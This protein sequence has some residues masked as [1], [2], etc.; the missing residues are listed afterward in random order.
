M[1]VFQLSL[2]CYHA[3]CLVTYFKYFLIYLLVMLEI[4]I[5]YKQNVPPVGSCPM[6]PSSVLLNLRYFNSLQMT[7]NTNWP[8]SAGIQ[9]KS[10]FCLH[11]TSDHTCWYT[12]YMTVI[13][14]LTQLNIRLTK[15]T[16]MDG[17]QMACT[18][19]PVCVL[20]FWGCCIVDCSA[21]SEWTYA[22]DAE[23]GKNSSQKSLYAVLSAGSFVIICFGIQTTWLAHM[24]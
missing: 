24:I 7:G 16:E 8:V 4:M 19:R 12:Q 18:W 1:H 9:A 21:A 6:K 10:K 5:C 2:D 11:S 3:C 23:K 13:W 22:K 14:T 17:W 20:F 15:K